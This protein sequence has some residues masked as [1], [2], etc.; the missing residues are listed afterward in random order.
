LVKSLR[1]FIKNANKVGRTEIELSP[2]TAIGMNKPE[3]YRHDLI[4]AIAEDSRRITSELGSEC[5]VELTGLNSRIE[6]QRVSAIDLV[7][8]IPYAMKVSGCS[9]GSSK[10]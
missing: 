4:A 1:G 8:Y 9:A 6:W 7:L 2:E 5:K 3:R 10:Q